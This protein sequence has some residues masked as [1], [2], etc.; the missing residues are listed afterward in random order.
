MSYLWVL[1][2]QPVLGRE[3]LSSGGHVPHHV[4]SLV[5]QT[6]NQLIANGR[7]CEVIGCN[8]MTV[9]DHPTTPDDGHSNHPQTGKRHGHPQPAMQ[10]L[11]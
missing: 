4:H 11:F 8:T 9:R 5:G 3:H 7:S 1:Q 6:D 2:Q 10:L